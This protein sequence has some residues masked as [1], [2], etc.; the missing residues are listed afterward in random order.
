MSRGDFAANEKSVTVPEATTARIEFTD[1][2]GKVTVLKDK[3]ALKAGEVLDGTFMSRAALISFLEAQ[4]EDAKKQGVLFSIHLKATMMK[5]SDPIIFG[6]AVRTFFREVFDKH[7]AAFKEV[8]V[9]PNNGL[10]DLYAA[11]KRLPK[12]KQ[13]EIEADIQAAYARRPPL[14]MVN[15]DKGHHQPARAE[16]R[17][18]RRLDPP[19]DP[20]LRADV[21]TGRQAARG[22]GR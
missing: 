7:A 5:V 4:I 3:L 10:G 11:I 12:A 21:G 20:R 19:D 8:G 16:R 18:H 15:S 9:D 14:A 13:A 6:V 1:K 17:D 2:T 22:Q